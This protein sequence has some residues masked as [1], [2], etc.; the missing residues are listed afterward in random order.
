M[1]EPLQ[2]EK[3]LILKILYDKRKDDLY[4]YEA[5]SAIFD[6]AYADFPEARE[7]LKAEVAKIYNISNPSIKKEGVHESV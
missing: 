7:W 6:R 2:S 4:K 5:I 3:D 1:Y